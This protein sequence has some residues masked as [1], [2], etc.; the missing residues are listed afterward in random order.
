MNKKSLYF[1]LFIFSFNVS[2]VKGEQIFDYIL[3]NGINVNNI[4][5]SRFDQNGFLWIGTFQ[6]VFRFDGKQ[7]I[8]YNDYF[9]NQSS[10]TCIYSSGID[11]NNNIYFLSVNNKL[12]KVNDQSD[13]EIINQLEYLK[14]YVFTDN[15]RIVFKVKYPK[16]FDML[17][18]IN[19]EMNLLY[20]L[21]N[22][23]FFWHYKDQLMHNYQKLM[24]VQLKDI[25]IGIKNEQ[26]IIIYNNK[27]QIFLRNKLVTEKARYFNLKQM[28]IHNPLNHCYLNMGDSLYELNVNNRNL[29]ELN[30]LLKKT[31]DEYCYKIDN[32][33]NNN[34]T[35]FNSSKRGLFILKN[36]YFKLITN[37]NK[38]GELIKYYRV[39]YDDNG[40]FNYDSFF[41]RNQINYM[42]NI[43]NQIVNSPQGL[44]YFYDN[45]ISCLN[46]NHKTMSLNFTFNDF[47]YSIY[48]PNNEYLFSDNNVYF[49]KNDHYQKVFEI[50]KFKIHTAVEFYDTSK[51]LLGSFQ[52]GLIIYNLKTKT[53]ERIKMFEQ[54]TIRLIKFDADLNIYWIFTYGNGI[55]FI[56]RNKN[57]IPFQ[58]DELQYNLYSHSFLK[59]QYKFYWIST[60]N[61]LFRYSEKSIKNYLNDRSFYIPYSQY[62]KKDGLINEEFNGSYMNSAVKLPNGNFAFANMS[63]VVV[64][65][66]SDYLTQDLKN[67][68]VI[69]IDKITLDNYK[70]DRKEKEIKLK[71]NFTNLEFQL[72]KA[73]FNSN[74]N[75][76]IEY[77]IQGLMK[78][79]QPLNKNKLLIL[80]LSQ[81]N[82][83][84]LF[85]KKGDINI[86]NI[87]K[88]KISVSALWY[89]STFAFFI[90]FLIFL[91]ILFS[92]IRLFDRNKKKRTLEAQ[93]MTES[94]LKALRSQIN[95]HYL[96]NSLTNLQRLILKDNKMQ[97]LEVL[98]LFGKV[99]RNILVQS[100]HP[101]TSLKTEIKTLKEYMNLE[102]ML[103]FENPQFEIEQHLV[104]DTVL[105]TIQIPSMLIQPFVENA[106]I[107]GLSKKTDDPKI[108]T[109]SFE[110]GD[111]LK[112]II[113]DNGV[114]RLPSTQQ[115]KRTSMGNVNVENRMKLYGNLLKQNFGIQII[116]LK[117]EN[118]L[119]K[120]TKVILHLPFKLS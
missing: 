68:E 34:Q 65:N 70:L 90:Y 79:W 113:E 49:L 13:L 12:F 46:F 29:I 61:G 57:I 66:P 109:I 81:G 99:M 50:N 14:D 32:Q 30:G 51:W 86:E 120:G 3:K 104:P 100:D 21:K 56:D 58:K 96:S 78:E 111:T 20:L 75:I 108:L 112:C 106:I 35:F 71:E 37:I 27:Y 9:F 72:A 1:F 62:N 11:E 80:T 91:V 82:Y 2:S 40:L 114:G 97:A 15:Q 116:D 17:K 19:F 67:N 101:F 94:E 83:N 102:G 73:S 95:P 98:S 69:I 47:Y 10:N 44:K 39:V 43:G 119:P 28:K 53:Q 60:N 59:D 23:D 110:F 48:N 63:G 41:K 24:I 38:S 64:F 55:F 18:N 31:N 16:F 54:A 76:G 74:E 115:N 42:E 6:G 105:E 8:N 87:I 7:L 117:D 85:R 89:K 92:F 93:K 5:Y 45:K 84:V 4:Q 88:Y 33:N 36:N 26:L 107:H 22:G 25:N 52:G 77:L 103:L 118:L